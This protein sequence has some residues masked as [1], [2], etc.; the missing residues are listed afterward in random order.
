MILIYETILGYIVVYN[1]YIYIYI[2]T[3]THIHTYIVQIC[4]CIHVYIYVCIYIH[5]S[6]VCFVE[7]VFSTQCLVRVVH[8]EMGCDGK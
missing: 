2:Y 5:T 1:I 4:T 7:A 8:L 6:N 3:H